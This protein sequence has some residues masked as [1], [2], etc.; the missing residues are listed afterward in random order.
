MGCN[1][2]NTLWKGSNLL[3]ISILK[4]VFNLNL[5]IFLFANTTS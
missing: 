3:F 1:L 5:I 2:V 4:F